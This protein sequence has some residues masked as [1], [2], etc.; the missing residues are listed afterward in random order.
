MIQ[1][2]GKADCVGCWSCWNACPKQ[3]IS[4]EEDSEGFRYPVINAAL[5]INCGKCERACPE[6]RDSFERTPLATYAARSKDDQIRKESSSGGVFTILAEKII[7][8]GG[9]VYGASFNDKWNVV[10]SEATKTEELA[11]FR[12][13][14][15]LQSLTGDTYSKIKAYL[16]S[17]RQVLYSGTPCQILGLKSFLG[18]EYDNLIT[19]DFVCHG[20]P[21]PM[22]WQEYLKGTAKEIKKISFRDK[23]YGWK[24]YHVDISSK[25]SQ[26]SETFQ[27]NK[28]MQVFLHN[29]CLRPSCYSCSFKSGRSGSDITLGDFWGIEHIDPAVDDD[30]GTSLVLVNTAKGKDLFDDLNLDYKSE[31]YEEAV[32]YNPSITDSVLTPPYRDLFIT[33]IGKNSFDKA[34]RVV[35]D[36]G[37]LSRI[38]RR[39]WRLANKK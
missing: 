28:Y 34:Y 5:C 21:S 37:I 9:V 19:V 12:G 23:T 18:K 7:S 29:L 8:S 26:I 20:V 15:Y 33:K 2:Q 27:Q 13:S 10:H 22:I 38:R 17:A 14:K 24:E 36:G 1:I 6:L 16:T 31:S 30:K 4:M 25:K 32:K 3:C 11:K 35:F 39:L